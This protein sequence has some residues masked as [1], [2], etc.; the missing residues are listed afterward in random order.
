MGGA[1][2]ASTTCRVRRLFRGFRLEPVTTT[3]SISGR[4]GEGARELLIGGAVRGGGYGAKSSSIPFRTGE[5]GRQNGSVERPERPVALIWD[6]ET[7]Q[8]AG[9]P[10]FLPI[11]TAKPFDALQCVRSDSGQYPFC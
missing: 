11:R 9:V 1:W 4:P 2:S 8:N 5:F 3:Y 10:P 6:T 7:V